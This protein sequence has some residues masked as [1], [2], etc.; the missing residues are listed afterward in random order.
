MMLWD[1]KQ[2][3]KKKR[4]MIIF[5]TNFKIWTY[6]TVISFYGF[7]IEGFTSAS[8]WEVSLLPR[9]PVNSN[10]PCIDLPLYCKEDLHT[11]SYLFSIEL[12]TLAILPGL[13]TVFVNP[14]F[15]PH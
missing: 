1:Q 2:D 11:Y 8:F 4:W 15:F 6:T 13:E 7:E 10:S 5:I 9:C 14:F 3:F 12:I